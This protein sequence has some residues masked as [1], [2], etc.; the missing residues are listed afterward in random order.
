MKETVMANP[1]PAAAH[2]AT[3]DTQTLIS[4]LEGLMPLLM[5][6]QSQSPAQSPALGPQQSLGLQQFQ[7]GD[8]GGL[9]MPNALVDHHATVSLVEDM[10][11]DTLRTLSAYLEA[12]AGQHPDLQGCVGLVTQAVHAF[13]MRDYGQTFALIWQAYRA[14]GMLRAVNPQLPPLRTV[15]TGIVPSPPTASIH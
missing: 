1:N 9:M 6:I 14:I 10:A 12:H 7:F 8:P 4:L 2:Q 11:A 5:R 13:A 3:P 15:A